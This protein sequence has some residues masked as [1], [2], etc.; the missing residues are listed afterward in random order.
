MFTLLKKFALMASSTAMSR[1]ASSKMMSGD[2]PPS[3][4][5]TGFR[6]LLAEA[7][8][9]RR[10]TSVDPVKLTWNTRA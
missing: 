9:M 2:L 6:L 1:S 8:I 3:S 7:S 4:R 10:P 5:D